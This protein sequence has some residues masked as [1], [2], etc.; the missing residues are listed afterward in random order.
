MKKSNR[1]IYLTQN[2]NED[3]K[4]RLAHIDNG[5]AGDSLIPE[6]KSF[7]VKYNREVVKVT[8]RFIDFLKYSDSDEINKYFNQ[9]DDIKDLSNI[10]KGLKEYIPNNSFFKITFIEEKA[11]LKENEYKILAISKLEA[12]ID[13][14]KDLLNNLIE[15]KKEYIPTDTQKRI[16]NYSGYNVV[17]GAAGTGKTDVAIHSYINS[18]PLDKIKNG[19][20][21]DDVFITYSKKLSD[22]VCYMMDIFWDDYKNPIKKNVYTTKDFLIQILSNIKFD[23][24]GYELKNNSYVNNKSLLND[25]IADN[26][27]FL[28]WT[29]N[30]FEFMNKVYVP[31]LNSIVEKYGIDYPYLFFRGIYKGK[32]IN[33]VSDE[34]INDYFTKKHN[35]DIKEFESLKTL[36][37]DY[38]ENSDD[39]ESF[40]SFEEWYKLASRRY[41]STFKQIPARFRELDG[42]YNIYTEYFDFANPVRE[43]KKYIDYFELFKREALLIEGYRG[44]TRK[45]FD[46]EIK[47]LYEMCIAYQKYLENNNLYDDNDLAYFVLLNIDKVLEDGSFKNIIVD[48]FQDMTERQVHTIVKLTNGGV[49]HIFGDFEQTINPTFLQMENVETIYMVN[50]INDYEK[51]ILSSS[52][53]YSQAICRELEALREKGKK[54]FGTE[55][56]SGY[57]PLVSNASKEFETGGNLLLNFNKGK[58]LLKDI[59]KAKLQ[60]IMYIVSDNEAKLELINDF[61][62]QADK[63]F[64]VSESKGREED[65]VVVYKL[66]TSKAAEY[67]SIFSDDYQYSRAGRI[68]YNQLYVGITRCKVNFLEIEDDTKLGPNTIKNLTDLIAVLL[69]ENIDLFKEELL[70]SKA[71]FYFRAIDSFRNLDFKAASDN[72]SFYLGTDFDNLKYAIKLL[73]EELDGIDNSDKLAELANE[74]KIKRRYDLARVIYVVL[75]NNNMQIVM[76]LREN[77]NVDRFS[78][79]DYK[80]IILNEE[81][82]LNDEDIEFISKTGYFD[83]KKNELRNKI[84]NIRAKG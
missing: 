15:W 11:L 18:L 42:L 36:L 38:V 20:I 62:V 49:A 35:L 47:I 16:A 3:L 53:R 4:N 74:Y 60:N 23:I 72:L 37:D 78:D 7:D 27:T 54:L 67:E 68:F 8:T 70:S 43:N 29:K 71:N 17:L 19:S 56:M 41:T 77:I 9:R 31:N 22:Y 84:S 40:D 79:L 45:D 12:K 1:K 25:V 58:E 2:L 32:I 28:N 51:Q 80:N 30:G 69:D 26:N 52:F 61:K 63:V 55:D 66:C 64:T 10:Y 5:I 48:E 44:E 83:R 73:N 34:E 14:I 39:L 46:D 76:D 75:D 24:K 81:K 57:L 33:K 82:Y 50:D 21:K 6:G 13:N 59:A 65:F